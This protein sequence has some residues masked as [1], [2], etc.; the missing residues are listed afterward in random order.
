MTAIRNKK[1]FSLIGILVA[2]CLLA[3]V[4]NGT[5]SLAQISLKQ[6]TQ[7]NL[8]FAAD[9]IRRNLI[10][11]VQNSN[12]WQNT[13][14][15]PANT[16]LACLKASASCTGAGGAF[17]VRDAQNNI[18]YDPL[19]STAVGFAGSGSPCNTFSASGNEACPLRM[20]LSWQPVCS[21]TCVN[22]Q[23]KLKGTMTYAPQAPQTKFAFNALNYSFEIL[24]SASASGAFLQ[25][26]NLSTS[27]S[28]CSSLPSIAGRNT[29]IYEGV[30][31]CPTGYLAVSASADC[32]AGFTYGGSLH[33]IYQL[34]L[35]Q[36]R[37]RCCNYQ[38]AGDPAVLVDRGKVLC[39]KESSG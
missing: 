21:G 2:A 19:T 37:I 6:Q 38:V 7:S 9:Q 30:V 11:Y 25:S 34:S 28:A 22:P 4:L 23:V 20:E 5:L 39:L 26:G 36:W 33:S 13:L 14:N 18:V 27:G 35:T 24:Q 16:S 12:A 3:V 31:S 15:D 32:E 8:T 1:G 17:R 10:Q 29:W